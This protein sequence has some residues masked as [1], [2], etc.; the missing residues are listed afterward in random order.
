MNKLSLRLY[1]KINIA[2]FSMMISS[3]FIFNLSGVLSS[4]SIIVFT[5]MIFL[6]YA[7]SNHWKIR[8]PI[9]KFHI[10]I[11][12]F[13]FFCFLSS[14]WARDGAVA[15]SMGI[16]IF[17]LLICMSIIFSCFIKLPSVEF[18]LKA[19]M[20][21]GVIVG[22]YT[23]YFYGIPT[24]F[25]MLSGTIR[26]GNDYANSNAIGMWGAVCS[27]VFFYF[28]LREHKFKYIAIIIPICLVAMSQSRTAL[29]EL[30]VGIF[31]IIIFKYK[32]H[33][34]TLKSIFG[35]VFAI[36]ITIMIIYFMSK[37]DIFAG[38]N[39]RMASLFD[40]LGGESVQ[41]GSVIQRQIYIKTGLDE[42]FKHPIFG[43]GIGNSYFITQNVTGHST[44]LHNNFVELLSCGGIVGFLLYYGLTASM[45][46]KLW[47]YSRRNIDFA[48]ICL[49]ILLIKTFSDYGTISYYSKQGYIILLICAMML[50]FN[51]AQ[52]KMYY[53]DKNTF[54]R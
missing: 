30:L 33:K 39:E 10:F 23:V 17:E 25:S 34:N 45:L 54:K 27:V 15:R 52:N 6:V 8:V 41:E 1:E 53:I 40:F 13:S 14:L 18:L 48:E 35:I 22:L 32:N 12:I 36:I 4:L 49:I 24:F 19:L 44:Y 47:K 5:G 38:L 37:L 11:M 9:E 7:Y 43:I 28:I 50:Y 46:I 16:T 31:L 29:I 21:S 42:F 26:I 2:L 3:F 51:K 20:W